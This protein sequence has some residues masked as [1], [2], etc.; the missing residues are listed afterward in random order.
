MEN[1]LLSSPSSD[2]LLVPYDRI[3][4]LQLQLLLELVDEVVG[5]R[6][7]LLIVFVTLRHRRFS[8][9]LPHSRRSATLHNVT[10]LKM[11]E[12]RLRTRRLLHLLRQPHW[13]F[14]GRRLLIRLGPLKGPPLNLTVN[15][16]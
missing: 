14:T 9:P 16:I 3:Q 13:S 12:C 15:L 10:L 11:R 5:L 4:P 6:V 2:H 1:T 7:H 8:L